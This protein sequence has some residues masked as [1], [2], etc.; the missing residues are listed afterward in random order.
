MSSNGC[1]P[2]MATDKCLNILYPHFRTP[3][4]PNSD[5]APEIAVLRFVVQVCK[6]YLS[7]A[8]VP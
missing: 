2:E 5:P 3:F 8:C 6:V 7:Y 1:E 4:F